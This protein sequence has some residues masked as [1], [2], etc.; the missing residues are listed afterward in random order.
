YV[1][2]DNKTPADSPAPQSPNTVTPG[3]GTQFPEI[4]PVIVNMSAVQDIT[5]SPNGWIDD[6]PG[7]VCGTGQTQTAGNNATSCMD[8]D[9]DNACDTSAA[10]VIDAFGRPTGNPDGNGRNRDFLGTALRDFQTNYLPPPQ[11]GNPEAGQTCTGSGSS[12]TLPI[13][14]FRRGMLTQ[15]FYVANWY[16]DQLF[17]LGFDEASANFQLINFSG[18]G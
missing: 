1:Q 12:G 14:Q 3:S 9:A 2:A 17:E 4:L 8:L 6:C 13:D 11:G 18:M 15:L 16:H 5:A 7:G 10:G